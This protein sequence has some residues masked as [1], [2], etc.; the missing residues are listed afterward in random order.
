MVT[1][2][3]D[4]QEFLSLSPIGVK[5]YGNISGIDIYSDTDMTD[6]VK[7][8]CKSNPITVDFSDKISELIDQ[9]KILIGYTDTTPH[10]IFKK[11]KQFL[12]F[13]DRNP[14]D[15]TYGFYAINE[16]K[17]LILLENIVNILGLGLNI[18]RIP[19]I[20]KH[21]LI[22]MAFSNHPSEYTRIVLK[23][24]I[25][26]YTHLT[27]NMLDYIKKNHK[28]EFNYEIK[29]K[30]VYNLILNLN[31]LVISK[32]EKLTM[33]KVVSSA[34]LIWKNYINQCI[35]NSKLSANISYHLATPYLYYLLGSNK[36]TDISLSKTA[37]L[38]YLKTYKTAFN[39]DVYNIT[40]PFQEYLT[41]SEVHCILGDFMKLKKLEGVINK[42]D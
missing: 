40:T 8:M 38:V 17:I 5:Q 32:S 31:N 22:H 35:D 4:L 11:L 23:D 21:E 28:L 9:R 10:I 14:L 27:K 18:S 16:D 33:N 39:L 24:L 1:E 37:I 2:K 30:N 34:Y 19:N 7:E 6:K 29:E 42:I 36:R 3:V 13:V 12:P 26:F 41:T 15:G 20:I 25:K